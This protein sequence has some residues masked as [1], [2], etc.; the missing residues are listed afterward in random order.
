MNDSDAKRW[1]GRSGV[2][3]LYDAGQGNGNQYGLVY[4]IFTAADGSMLGLGQYWVD[5]Q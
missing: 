4:A 5:C 2:L 3:T 1:D